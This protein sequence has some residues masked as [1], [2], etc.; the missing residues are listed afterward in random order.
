MTKSPSTNVHPDLALA[1]FLEPLASGKRILWIGDPATQAPLHLCAA[2]KSLRVLDTSMSSSHR[3]SSNPPNLTVKKFRAGPLGFKKGTFDL[4][5]VPDTEVLGEELGSKALDLARMVDRGLVVCGVDTEDDNI[6][7][8][9]LEKHLQAAFEHLRMLGQASMSGS[10][11]ADFSAEDP[12]VIVDGSL[13]ASSAP[14]RVVAIASQ[15]PTAVDEYAIIQYPGSAVDGDRVRQLEGDVAERSRE[16]LALREE[17]SR[18]ERRMMRVQSQL[19]EREGELSEVRANTMVFADSESVRLE[20]VGSK[21]SADSQGRTHSQESVSARDGDGTREGRSKSSSKRR[22]KRRHDRPSS[23]PPELKKA[24]SEEVD[25]LSAKLK[26][27]G[28]TV[29]EL[30]QELSRRTALVR[31][32]V[33]ELRAT[34]NTANA[35]APIKEPAPASLPEKANTVESVSEVDALHEKL[36]E[37][38]KV[39]NAMRQDAKAQSALVRDMV[40]NA[41]HDA[42]TVPTEKSADYAD[43]EEKLAQQASIVQETQSELARREAIVRDLTELLN[44]RPQAPS[45]FSEAIAE[46]EARLV[47]A[48]FE[49]QTLRAN[50][51]SATETVTDSSGMAKRLAESSARN[52]VLGESLSQ[53]ERE[54]DEARAKAL[55]V[56]AQA[57]ALES[58]LEGQRLG[59]ETRIAL[60]ASE[61][62]APEPTTLPA[63]E[64]LGRL[65]GSRDG[66]R[67]RLV[68]REL[69]LV[70][71][72]GAGPSRLKVH[73]ELDQTRSDAASMR[74]QNAELLLRVA[75]LSEAQ[76]SLKQASQDRASSAAA[77]DALITRLQMDLSAFE[78]EIHLYSDREARIQEE[79][80][81]LKEAL[82]DASS[83]SDERDAAIAQCKLLEQRVAEVENETAQRVALLQAQYFESKQLADTSAAS[84]EAVEQD[85]FALKE[86]LASAQS[87]VRNA[88][89]EADRLKLQSTESIA[90][91]KAD[92]QLAIESLQRQLK[93]S[94]VSLQK[95]DAQRDALQQDVDKLKVTLNNTR[96][97]LRELLRDGGGHDRTVTEITAVGDVDAPSGEALD[98][99]EEQTMV[100]TLTAQLEE[101]NI[102]IRSLEKRISSVAPAPG[103][104][105]P[106][107]MR[108]E[109]LELQERA[110]RLAEELLHARQARRAA[111][112]Q[113]EAS[114]SS[115]ADDDELSMVQA[116]LIARE[117]ELTRTAAKVQSLARDAD[118]LRKACGHARQEIQSV[119]SDPIMAADAPATARLRD[120]LSHLGNY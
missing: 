57:S 61:A 60:L 81:R 43:L 3:T 88:E 98:A 102:R 101:R 11:L 40:E 38:A 64:A 63:E 9:A 75:E 58:R 39:I 23:P 84:H 82:V 87:R 67:F 66:L 59:F 15:S 8:V 50:V 113:L 103:E 90:S 19:K 77:K 34:K 51:E 44:E 69:A 25:A 104:Y 41:K 17:L 111:E 99:S 117:K 33:E 93:T 2:A 96:E 42:G 80:S 16:V 22:G 46:A 92:A 78:R 62:Q 20:G 47:R 24:L 116:R 120:V 107:L 97:T 7:V 35:A 85:I 91:V 70:A 68:D 14:D 109:M 37:Q 86:E 95:A 73:D 106:Q 6:E 71:A 31:D 53:I 83:L 112:S 27:Q 79:C 1:V 54:R 5:V 114:R 48:D 30:Q 29:A 108:R 18:A 55:S 45:D 76:A 118:Q 28:Q 94:D 74:A 115:A 119:L 100:R 65:K 49:I 4:V 10:V 12:E 56:V 105:A 110:S 32:L 36:S 72:Q 26:I 13:A 52:V 21:E 89:S